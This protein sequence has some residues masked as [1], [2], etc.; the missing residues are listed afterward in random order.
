MVSRLYTPRS[1]CGQS[2]L[3]FFSRVYTYIRKNTDKYVI[4]YSI[5]IR[6]TSNIMVAEP[7]I[8]LS[9]DRRVD[10]R[11]CRVHSVP[12]FCVKDFIRRTANRR[13]GPLDALQYWMSISL[14]LQHERDII[15]SYINRF[16]GPYELP[17]ICVNANGLLILLHHMEKMYKLVNHAYRDE[18]NARLQEVIN[19]DGEQFIEE[20]DD[21][22]VDAQTTEAGDGFGQP[23]D[24]QFWYSP[25]VTID[26]EVG[27]VQIDVALR[28]VM[29][30]NE[31]LQER[32][33]IKDK[34]FNGLELDKNRESELLNKRIAELEQAALDKQT[35]E[36]SFSLTALIKAIGLNTKPNQINPLCRR[37]VSLF[38]KQF[39]EAKPTKRHRVVFFK[40]TDKKSV[41]QILRRVHL[42]MELET[43]QKEHLVN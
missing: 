15:C 10:V 2:N 8:F 39:P 16:Q 32:L 42:Q 20:Y 21:G 34:E 33:T 14:A 35:K 17:N 1:R 28:V 29:D 3:C 41:E 37:V 5:H 6:L 27:D 43:D 36:K 31:K 11:C 24:S 4:P 9:N 12:Y 19:G 25:S 22:E 13:M 40:P 38:T 23:I 7:F 30:R 26:N 18:V